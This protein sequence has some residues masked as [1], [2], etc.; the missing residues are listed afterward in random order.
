MG[1]KS[2]TKPT[3]SWR[4][5]RNKVGLIFQ[6]CFHEVSVYGFIILHVALEYAHPESTGFVCLCVFKIMG[7]LRKDPCP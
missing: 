3:K 7:Y 4:D 6:P 1:K 5:L 2:K